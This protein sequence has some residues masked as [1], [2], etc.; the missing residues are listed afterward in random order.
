MLHQRVQVGPT[1]QYPVPGI[2][3]QETIMEQTIDRLARCNRQNLL[4]PSQAVF[5]MQRIRRPLQSLVAWESLDS[6]GD[7]LS[8]PSWESRPK[9]AVTYAEMPLVAAEQLV[10]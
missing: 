9:P 8:N 7:R 5:N 1:L 3:W 2:F 4:I 6:R 10:W